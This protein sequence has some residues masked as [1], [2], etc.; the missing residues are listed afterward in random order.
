MCPA[1]VMACGQGGIDPVLC[2]PGTVCA[3]GCC[4]LLIP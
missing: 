2:P 1:G 4:L 3:N